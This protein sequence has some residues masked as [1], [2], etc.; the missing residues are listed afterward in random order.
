M[1]GYD[2]K[3]YLF[4]WKALCVNIYWVGPF[5]SIYFH[6]LKIYTGSV[7]VHELQVQIKIAIENALLSKLL[8]ETIPIFSFNLSK[9]HQQ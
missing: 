2:K 3:E 9:G 1:Q 5:K 6:C 8:Y 4:S 7:V